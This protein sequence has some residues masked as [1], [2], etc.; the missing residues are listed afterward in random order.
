MSSI[1]SGASVP[2]QT[3]VSKI[4][5]KAERLAKALEFYADKETYFCEEMGIKSLR[6]PAFKDSGDKARQAL[7][8]W[9]G[10]NKL[11]PES[12]RG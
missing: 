2:E 9:R 5:V 7:A 10:K 12:G 1:L 4:R 6:S 8:E 11:D 3:E